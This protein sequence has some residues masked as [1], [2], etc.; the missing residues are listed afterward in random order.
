MTVQHTRGKKTRSDAITVINAQTI[1]RRNPAHSEPDR[2]DQHGQYGRNFFFGTTPAEL[3]VRRGRDDA[4]ERR[5]QRGGEGA[6]A[7]VGGGT[8][9]RRNKHLRAHHRGHGRACSGVDERGGHGSAVT[10]H[11][12][13][14]GR[15]VEWSRVT[16]AED[17]AFR[18][19]EV[20]SASATATAP[21]ARFALTRVGGTA[22]TVDRHVELIGGN[23][24]IGV[25]GQQPDDTRGSSQAGEQ[26]QPAREGRPWHAELAGTRDNIRGET[27]P[28]R[29]RWS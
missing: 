28:R 4:H 24:L 29:A 5:H 20:G 3:R 13:Q 10:L 23:N 18:R 9:T 1:R 8:R 12:V 2:G 27:R 15:G 25:E 7:K 21:T 16:T 17:V 22:S 14:A 6:S 26:H 11:E 19:R